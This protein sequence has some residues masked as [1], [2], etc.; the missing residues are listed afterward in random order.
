L[1]SKTSHQIS[2]IDILISFFLL[3]LTSFG[4]PIAHI[5]YFR[6]TFVKDKKWIDDD[7][8]MEFVSL[9]NFLPGPSSSQVGM[10]IGYHFKGI[11]GAILAWVGF[12]IPS[13]LI[14]IIFGYFIINF[15]DVISSGFIQGLK[16][17]V[18]IIVFQAIWGMQK[19]FLKDF[20]S[21]SI[22]FFTA[23]ILILFP[24]SLNQLLC[25]IMSGLL[26]TYFYKNE[27]ISEISFYKTVTITLSSYVSLGLFFSFLFFLPI[28]NSIFETE[29]TFLANIFF[30]VGSL[31][32]GGG[33]VVLPLLQEE[34]VAKGLI[35]KDIFLAGY[36]AAQAIPGPL[37]T[38]SSYLG[39]FLANENNRLL[40]S[41]L[42]MIFIFLPSFFL[43]IGTLPLWSRLRKINKVIHAFKAINASVIGILVAAFY[44]PIILSSLKSISDVI[45]I[46]IAFMILF[47][48]KT[49][50]WLA[51]LILIFCGFGFSVIRF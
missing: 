51:V 27:E 41:I 44:D 39:I 45:L 3:G 10:S 34:F 50:Q 47:F 1:L 33:H 6:N 40:T 28:I 36:G 46:F 2:H 20:C 38:F 48:T 31:V 42:C 9:C 12:T 19:N 7:T 49:P 43:I 13:A 17:V 32:F 35:E 4:G 23:L 11:S 24:S 5:S 18:V 8:Y 37:F 21:Y 16:S 15:D 22:A 25:L 26:G 14:L 29:I 30:K